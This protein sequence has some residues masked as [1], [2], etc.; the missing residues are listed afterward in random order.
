MKIAFV[1][2][3]NYQG[4]GPVYYPPIHLCH[5]ATALAGKG[6]E[7]KIFDYSGPFS[8]INQYYREIQ[9]YTPDVIGMTC[10]TLY[11]SH[12]NMLS[13]A[14][15][16]YLPK[17]AIVAG[18]YH[19]TAWPAWTLENM[20]HIDYV[21]KGEGD[22]AVL[23]L[24]E[25]LTGKRSEQTV[26]GL[27]YRKGDAIGE[28]QQDAIENLD[29]LPQLDR[30][31]L[32]PYY[33]SGIYWHMAARGT[34]DSMITSRGCP[35]HCKFCFKIEKKYRCRSV[36]HVMIEFDDLK[37]RGI[38]SI[39]IQDESF[40]A[41]KERCTLIADY[42]IKGNYGF[43]LKV[44]SR[45]SSI[46]E[47]F[48]RKLKRA[49]VRQIVYGIETGSQKMLNA[50]DKKTTVAMNRRAIELTKRVG[51]GCYAD[52]M[53]GMPGETR[54]TIDETISFLLRTKPIAG[55][56]S[57]LYPLPRTD[58]YDEAKKDGTLIGDWTIEGPRPWV[59]LPWTKS[60]EDLENESLRISRRTHR[61]I[62]T[63]LYFLKHHMRVMSWKQINY[64]YR[65]SK[66]LLRSKITL[67]R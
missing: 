63:A 54:E 20:P 59:K 49:G 27:V 37:R 32:E 38:S 15:R 22:R 35:Y 29:A 10:C 61:D 55:H 44:R 4:R 43:E 7:V 51:I 40:T 64:L 41:Y 1:G 11:L 18:G 16:A 48:L 39:H 42:L 50:M 53:I 9:K 67:L 21:I 34:L 65:W 25:M 33:R 8:N 30:S 6:Y 17:T 28:N 60:K 5:L 19:P 12:F 36:D 3:D 31:L 24:A 57:V 26:P 2:V 45:V 52:M 47:E 46:D 66:V 62:G 23:F 56:V 58:I 13:K 14:L